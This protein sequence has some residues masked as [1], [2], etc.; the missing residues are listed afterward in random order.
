MQSNLFSFFSAQFADK[1][2]V[3]STQPVTGPVE[4]DLVT[5]AYVG[6]GLMGPA[7]TWSAEAVAAGPAGTW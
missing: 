6:G 7:G 2:S 1:S 5:L 3:D 4:L